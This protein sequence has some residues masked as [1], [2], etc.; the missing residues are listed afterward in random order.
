MNWLPAN[1]VLQ[2]RSNIALI[3]TFLIFVWLPTADTLL[4]FDH[5]PTPNENRL[6]AAFPKFRASLAGIHDYV[7]GTEAYFGDHFG[8]RNRLI[9]WERQWKWQFFHDARAMITIIGKDGWLYFSDGRTVD[10]IRGTHPFSDAELDA[11]RTLLTGRRDWLAK[12]GIRYL[13]VLPPDKHTIYSEHLPDWLQQPG[14]HG[15]RVD[16]FLAH[17]RS[18]SDVPVLDLREALFDAKMK[19]AIYEQTD[20]HWN[21][22]GAFAAYQRI[23]REV[24]ALGIPATAVARANFHD[25]R[26][27]EP[28]GDL[29]VM[30]GLENRLI[31][32]QRTLLTALPPLLPL[33][34]PADPNLIPK[35]WVPG[36]EPRVSVYPS[37]SGKV[38]MF[39]DSF[40]IALTKFFGYSFNRVVYVWQEHWDKPFIER[41]RPDIVIDE[42]LERILIDRDPDELRKKDEQPNTQ[43]LADH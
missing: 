26:T 32:K 8:F 25:T 37:A 30:L 31:E 21:D 7:A 14:R 12:R 10:D 40:G 23:V 39:R 27:D 17:M 20:S 29:A 3:A 43:I 11:W 41:E 13:F 22:A 34:S 15:R 4:H 5:T 35:K 1:E 18:H 19:E 42:L 16:Q 28:G 38:V 6:P 36:T 24:S 33:D 9:H 2:R